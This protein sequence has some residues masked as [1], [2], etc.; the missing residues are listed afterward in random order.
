MTNARECKKNMKSQD[1]FLTTN[2][3][4][5]TWIQ[6][7]TG[8]QT[9][10]IPDDEYIA[11]GFRNTP[12]VREA[13]ARFHTGANVELASFVETYKRIRQ[14]MYALRKEGAKC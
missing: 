11:F 9:S 3:Y 4:L 2:P 14:K 1:L 5:A 8:E 12:S 6:L 7:D 10:F 13:A